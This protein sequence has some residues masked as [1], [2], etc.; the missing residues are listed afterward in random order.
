ML[1]NDVSNKKRE[2]WFGH[3]RGEHLTI[4]PQV[5]KY[6][7]LHNHKKGSNLNKIKKYATNSDKCKRNNIVHTIT[8]GVGDL[9][10]HLW[11]WLTFLD[12][13]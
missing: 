8:W 5:W 6:G 10:S 4:H 3:F 2:R 1:V 9:Q 13:F 12:K 7:R 11:K